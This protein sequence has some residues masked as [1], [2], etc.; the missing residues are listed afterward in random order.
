MT[1]RV[2]FHSP[3]PSPDGERPRN[4]VLL[5]RG[6][7][8]QHYTHGFLS[9]QGDLSAEAE[10]LIHRQTKPKRPPGPAERCGSLE[11]RP[12]TG[13]SAAL[14][15]RWPLEPQRRGFFSG[16]NNSPPIRPVQIG[17]PYLRSKENSRQLERWAPP[18]GAS[19]R[20]RLPA[21]AIMLHY[22][23]RGIQSDHENIACKS[24]VLN[25]WP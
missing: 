16:R 8:L 18:Q 14:A 9:Y 20:R 7:K 11:R 10:R 13:L 3:I 25:S 21:H 24:H 4:D 6:S 2:D 1:S 19:D 17:S 23:Q 15:G 5:F 12:A 22:G